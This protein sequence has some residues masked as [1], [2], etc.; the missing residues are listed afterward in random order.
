MDNNSLPPLL[1]GALLLWAGIYLLW[2][3]TNVGRTVGY[4]NPQIS[5]GPSPIL[6][7]IA[8]IVGFGVALFLFTAVTR[9]TPAVTYFGLGAFEAWNV[10]WFFGTTAP[11]TAVT[12]HRGLSGAAEMWAIPLGAVIAVILLARGLEADREDPQ[13]RPVDERDPAT[14]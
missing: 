10:A 4:S 12:F 13:H 6:T 1:D 9:Q 11:T 14:E 2:G 8:T 5:G 7:G 3:L